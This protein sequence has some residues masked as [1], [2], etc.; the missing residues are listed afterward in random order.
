MRKAPYFQ[1]FIHCIE[2]HI[3]SIRDLK[4]QGDPKDFLKVMP[5][6]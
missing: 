6:Q 2:D 3:Q 1:E 4:P 5:L